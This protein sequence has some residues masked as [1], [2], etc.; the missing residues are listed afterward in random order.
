MAEYFIFLYATLAMFV[1]TAMRAHQR[2]ERPSPQMM[3]MVGWGLFSLSS[4]LSLL[5]FS[6]AV[7]LAVGIQMPLPESFNAPLF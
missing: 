2:A 1:V 5:L 3:T 7:A 6:V 4:T